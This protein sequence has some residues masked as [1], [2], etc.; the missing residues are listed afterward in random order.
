MD[1][2]IYLTIVSELIVKILFIILLI[3]GLKHIT[4]MIR[5]ERKKS[6]EL[7]RL[8]RLNDGIKKIYDVPIKKA[9]TF[10]EKD[11]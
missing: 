3:A 1:T 5:N 10:F 7:E 11:D 4:T 9:R 2:V 6:Q 8:K